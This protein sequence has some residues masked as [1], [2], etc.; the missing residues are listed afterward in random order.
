MLCSDFA[1]T[2]PIYLDVTQTEKLDAEVAKVDLVI[3]LI[4]YVFHV[5]VIQS[6]IRHRK[7]VVTTS[8]ITPAMMQ[9]DI[10]LCFHTFMIKS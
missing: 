4:P 9:L 3:S 1:N 2:T 6:A 5:L 7:N 10:G 8:Y